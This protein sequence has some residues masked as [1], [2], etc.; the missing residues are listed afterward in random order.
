MTKEFRR[1]PKI[2]KRNIIIKLGLGAI[3]LT[4]FILMCIFVKPIILAIAPG[5]F[6]IFLVLSGMKMLVRCLSKEYIEIRGTCTSVQKSAFRRH[7]RCIIVETENG[8]VKFPIHIKSRVIKQGNVV[9]AYVPENASIYEHGG[10]IIIC[11][12]YGIEVEKDNFANFVP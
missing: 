10:E 12:L 4:I 5:V 3:F 8:T 11:E 1:L 7:I 9:V 6:A 2:L